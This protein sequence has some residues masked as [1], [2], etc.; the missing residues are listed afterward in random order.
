MLVWWMCA[1]AVAQDAPAGEAP[2]EAST[3]R[4][5]ELFDNGARLYE[6]GQYDAAVLAFRE[7]LKLSGES[8]LYY[9]IANCLERMGQLEEARKELNTYRA[10]APASERETLDRRL[11]ALDKRIADQ[12]AKAT[13]APTPVAPPA[14]VEVKKHPRWAL[15]GAGLVVAAGGGVGAG[16]TAL[17]AQEAQDAR[18][19][20]GYNTM[21][22]LNVVSWSAVGVG[23]GV[24]V[25]GLVLPVS[26][27]V[28]ATPH[29]LGVRF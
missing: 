8:A 18:D 10:L 9:N 6:E 1:Q 25:L 28:F 2:A 16:V 29:G 23:A 26:S 14:P 13:P 5:A 21:R 3:A 4:A 27:P 20:A 7:S 11:A 22:T 12:A 19:E 15:V 24:A 17:Q